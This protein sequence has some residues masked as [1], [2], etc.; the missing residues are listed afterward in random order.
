METAR[1]GRVDLAVI[2][3]VAF[4]DVHHQHAEAAGLFHQLD[5]S[6]EQVLFL[7]FL[8]DRAVISAFRIGERILKVD[9]DQ[10]GLRRT[11]CFASGGSPCAIALE[12]AEQS[13]ASN[14]CRYS[15]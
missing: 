12:R 2:I 7:E 8:F 13:S 9:E 11:S 15:N 10:S 5:R 1:I 4:G 6:V 3:G 14:R